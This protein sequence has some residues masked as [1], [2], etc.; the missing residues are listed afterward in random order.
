MEGTARPDYKRCVAI[1][2]QAA[3]SEM[4]APGALVML[5]PVVVGALFGTQCLAGVLAGSLVSGVQ[6]AVSMSNTGGAWD[7]AKKYIEVRVSSQGLPH[8]H[9]A[10]THRCRPS[11]C[12]EVACARGGGSESRWRAPQLLSFLTPTALLVLVAM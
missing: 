3:I 10:Y 12:C 9:A 2:T 8:A 6:L 5:T 7:N 4:I 11:M 1:S